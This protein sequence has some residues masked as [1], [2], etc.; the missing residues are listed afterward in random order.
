MVKD[1]VIV[2]TGGWDVIPLIED[3]NSDSKRFNFIGFLEKDESKHGTELYG[4]PIIGGD[5]LLLTEFKNCAVVNNVMHTTR[6]HELV[7]KVLKE[8]FLVKDFPNLIHPSIDPRFFSIGQGNILYK[9][10]FIGMGAQIGSF[11]IIERATIGHETTI[12]DYNLLAACLVGSRC[13]M[14]NYNL[15]GNSVS[16]TNNVKMGD[17]NELGT[18]SVLVTKIKSGRHLMGNPAID[19]NEYA[20]LIK[21]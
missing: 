13:K 4:Y 6:A 16:I 1:L 20:K 18:G 14:G 19:I 17:D 7:A 2:G 12:G 3:I 15:I 11:N 5:D 21:L 9:G 8:K 10:A